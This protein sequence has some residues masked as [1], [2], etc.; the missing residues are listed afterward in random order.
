MKEFRQSKKLENV[1]YEIRG[2]VMEA[3]QRLVREGCSVIHLNTGN[4]PAFGLFAPEEIIR[5]AIANIQKAEAYCDSK[6]L[7]LARQAIVQTANAKGISGITPDDVY[8]GN[9]AS[10]MIVMSMQGL[11]DN[12]D[13]VLVPAPDYPLWTAAVNLA[14]GKAVHYLCDEQQEWQP[15][16]A[17]I[18]RK[19]TACTKGIVVINPNNPTGAVYSKDLLRK[20]V[21]IAEKHQL[22]VFADEIYDHILYDGIV[23]HSLATLSEDL[24]FV[25]FNG[26]SKSHRIPGMRAGWMIVSGNRKIAKDYID[27][28]NILSSMRLCGNVT[29]QLTIP[30]AL[31]DFNS[32]TALTNPGGR[33]FE[34]RDFAWKIFNDIPGMSCVK[35]R[36]ALYCFPKLDQKRYPIHDDQKFVL[37]F[38]EQK[39]VQLVQGTGFNWPA[40]DHFRVVFLPP[41]IEMEIVAERLRDF[42]ATYQQN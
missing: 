42:L 7:Y 19:I 6:G 18:E 26:L 28:L 20:I 9:G 29:A 12:G 4:P 30:A 13:E 24:L 21:K 8:I 22:I 37:D 40:P 23:H 16:P 27:G 35:P 3:A 11:L 14:G 1:C 33:L 41:V 10:E 17:E 2:P 31:S 34:Q 39:H 36:S 5:D 38:L 15:D 32:I 25:T